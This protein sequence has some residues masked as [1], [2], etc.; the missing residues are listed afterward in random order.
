R[1]RAVGKQ[2]ELALLDAV[3]HIAARAVDLLVELPRTDLAPLQRGDE[4]RIGLAAGHL[5]L[6]DDPALAAPTV[7]RGVAEERKSLKQ[8]AVLPVR[9][10]SIVAVI[11]SGMIALSRR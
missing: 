10:L 8:R 7:Q 2:V 1:R 4:A 3:L 6:A 9:M 5:G 11:N